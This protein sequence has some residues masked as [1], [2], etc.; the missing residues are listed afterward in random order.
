MLVPSGMSTNM[1]DGNQQT[2]NQ[3]KYLL[4]NLFFEE[5]INLKVKRF[6]INELFKEQNCLK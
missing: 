4:P 3:Q 1:A 5:L 6:L 2:R